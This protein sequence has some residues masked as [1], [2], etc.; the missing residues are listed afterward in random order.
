MIIHDKLN[1][2][3]YNQLTLIFSLA[4]WQMVEIWQ[5]CAV[6]HTSMKFC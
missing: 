4:E 3:T 1:N 5:D 2:I 6:C